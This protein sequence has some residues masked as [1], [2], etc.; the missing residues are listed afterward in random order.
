MRIIALDIGDVRIGVAMSDVIGMFASPLEVIDRNKVNAVDR[1][2]K[3]VEEYK[4][5]TIVAGL[6]KSL[7]GEE[8]MQAQ[9]VRE[10]V[11]VLTEELGKEII[12]I[13]ERY[14]TVAADRMLNETTKK[15]AIEKRK[16]VDKIAATFILQT[17]LDIKR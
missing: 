8:K 5:D 10:F 13:D 9:K 12:F 1:I 16:V 15:N 7:N 3:I 2:K 14:S 6:P 17:Y 11:K 4:V